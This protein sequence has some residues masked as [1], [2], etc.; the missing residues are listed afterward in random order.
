M[1]HDLTHTE[2]IVIQ[3]TATSATLDCIN[4][5]ERTV[6]I[7]TSAIIN[8]STDCSLTSDCIKIDR[9]SFTKF[10]WNA[11]LDVDFAV[12]EGGDL[13]N[14]KPVSQDQLDLIRNNSAMSIDLAESLNNETLVQLDT[15][16]RLCL[17]YTSPSPRD[18]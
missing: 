17:L 11:D 15:F 12:S 7:P 10:L 18:S 16:S 9:I 4:Q 1:A 6:Q 2:I 5:K 13:V 14:F 3:E 8:L